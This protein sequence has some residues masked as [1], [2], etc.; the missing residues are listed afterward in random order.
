MDADR[1]AYPDPPLPPDSPFHPLDRARVILET[2]AALAFYDGFPLSEGHAL[3]VP[4]K[5]VA[6]LFEL[7][8]VLQ[9]AVWEAVRLTRELL[10]EKYKPDGFNI[11]I[12][13]GRAAGQTVPH[14]HVHVIPRY[15]GDLADPR[16]GIRWVLPERAAYWQEKRIVTAAILRRGNEVLLTRRAPGEKLAGL[17]EFPGG[18]AHI[19][20]APEDCLARELLE[21]LSLRCAVGRKVA[22]SEYRYAHGEFAIVAYEAEILSGSMT[23]TVHDQAE[24]VPIGNLLDYELA[25][26]DIPIAR[27]VRPPGRKGAS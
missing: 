11:G 19:G 18:K 23:L 10:E 26:A 13:D 5:P 25:P 4:R 16:G 17:W 7:D 20:E 12:N 27:A 22:E 21:E 9:A 2:D 8:A 14:A 15:E 24:W 3:V 6:S 1:N